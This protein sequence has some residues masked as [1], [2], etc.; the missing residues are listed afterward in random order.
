[1]F[2]LDALS[3]EY[4]NG[5]TI[6]ESS[7]PMPGFEGPDSTL[8]REAVAKAAAEAVDVMGRYEIPEGYV[9]TE[10]ED[11]QI[12]ISLGEREGD[13]PGHESFCGRLFCGHRS[14][15]L[16]VRCADGGL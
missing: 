4:I 15:S 3:G 5:A 10:G 12:R 11:D 16:W 6:R 2:L 13:Q 1:V 9:I 7:D 14:H 8:V